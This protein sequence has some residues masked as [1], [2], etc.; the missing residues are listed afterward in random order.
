[1]EF[2]FSMLIEFNLKDYS[3]VRLI[4]NII[5]SFRK[6]LTSSLNDP[7]DQSLMHPLQGRACCTTQPKL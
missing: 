4:H 5:E 2:R 3:P 6:I 1:M 7:R